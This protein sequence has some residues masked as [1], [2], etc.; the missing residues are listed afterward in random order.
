M[1][2]LGFSNS[3]VSLILKCISS[4]SYCILLNGE[5][6]GFFMPSRG[7]RQGDPL[8]PYLFLLCV[9]VLSCLLLKAEREGSI[10]SVPVGRGP[11]KVNHLFFADD[12][13]IFCKANSLE[14][15]RVMRI[16][17]QYELASGQKLN[18]EKS[19]IYF[20]KNTPSENKSTILKIAGVNA[21][22]SFEKY[23]GLPTMVGRTKIAS[24]HNLIDRVWTRVTNW[25]TNSLSIVGKEILVKSVLQAIPTY[26]MEVFLLPQSIINRLDQLLRKFWWG[27]NEGRAKIQWVKWDK[28]SKPKLQ[29]GMGFRN[30]KSFN[31]ALLA[32]QGWNLLTKPD[33]LPAQ[34]IKQKY[35]AKGSLLTANMGLRPSLAWRSLKAGLNLLKEGLIWRVGN[36]AQVKIWEDR[37]LPRPHILT[38][39]NGRS[40]VAD[41]TRVEDLIDPNLRRWDVRLL[42]NL[43]SQECVETI[44]TIPIRLGHREDRLSW[45]CTSN[46]MFTVKSASHLHRAL[47]PSHESGPS[48][49]PT[50]EGFWKSLWKLQSSKS[51][52]PPKSDQPCLLTSDLENPPEGYYKLNWDASLNTIEGLVGVGAIIKDNCGRVMGTLKA[53]REVTLSPYA[54]EAYALMLV[55]L[56]CK[57]SGINEIMLEED[58]L[59]VVK[60][61]RDQEEDRRM[62]GLIIKDTVSILR[63]FVAWSVCHTKRDANVAAHV[64]AKNALL[65]EFDH[66]DLEDIPCCIKQVV[67]SDACNL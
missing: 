7:L 31:L 10:S 11:V 46:G 40:P 51:K 6:Q 42:A 12:S 23:L 35:F 53:R 4:V 34:I 52:G 44:R 20:S 59:Q 19:S 61:L 33:S 5:P 17:T 26:T 48:A 58:S 65:S 49:S 18:K 24:F 57:E 3:W 47:Q 50:R 63:S 38:S 9:E 56:F 29:G 27:F 55:V 62:G 25:K 45:E 30:F 2:K 66:Y 16:L 67:A 15:S 21:T 54:A 14:W 36:G 60:Q 39:N 8:S 43:F 41:V 1:S 64:L 28:L 32:K 22:D 13:L 37:W